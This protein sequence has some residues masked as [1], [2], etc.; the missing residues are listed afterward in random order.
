M[1]WICGQGEG[2]RRGETGPTIRKGRC[3]GYFGTKDGRY[4]Y[5]I[6]LPPPFQSASQGKE[7]EE[8]R[9]VA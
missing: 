6:S 4:V 9:E 8:E 7:E 2:C 3:R 1:G 5:L